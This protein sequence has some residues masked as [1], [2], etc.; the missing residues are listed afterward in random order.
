MR[1]SPARTVTVTAAGAVG[2]QV[3]GTDNSAAGYTDAEIEQLLA[4]SLGRDFLMHYL[5]PNS[6]DRAGATEAIGVIYLPIQGAAGNVNI[7]AGSFKRTGNH[8]QL[9]GRV[10]DLFGANPRGARF[11]S[12]RIEVTTTM[13]KPG[14]PRCC[15]TGQARWSIERN[16][17]KAHRLR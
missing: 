1:A 13:P 14:D 6:N 7:K 9:A 11:L 10:H 17:L 12:D 2:S 16:S 8:F 3:V 15:P 5:L 4:R